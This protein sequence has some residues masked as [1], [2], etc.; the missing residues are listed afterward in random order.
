MGERRQE[1]PSGWSKIAPR[2]RKYALPIV[3]AAGAISNIIR[4]LRDVL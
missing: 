3:Q 1:K 2:L 4:L